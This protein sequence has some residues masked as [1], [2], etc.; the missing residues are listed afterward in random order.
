MKRKWWDTISTSSFWIKLSVRSPFGCMICRQ[1]EKSR[2]AAGILKQCGYTE[3]G[4]RDAAA[5]EE[6]DE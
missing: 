2:F 3:R 1:K 4:R 5:Q 6:S